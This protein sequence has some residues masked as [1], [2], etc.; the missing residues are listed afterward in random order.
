MIEIG[1]QIKEDGILYTIVSTINYQDNL[2]IYMINPN[3]YGDFRIRSI[4]EGR[5]TPVFN[6]NILDELIKIFSEIR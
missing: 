6:T 2:Y 4:N 5:L 3:N 1:K